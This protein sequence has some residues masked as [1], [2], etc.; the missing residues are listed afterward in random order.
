MSGHSRKAMTLASCLTVAIASLWMGGVAE[1]SSSTWDG[2]WSG[3]LNNQEPVS[4][5]IADGKVVAY[6]IRGG[7]PFPIGYNKVTVSTVSFGDPT[8]FTV[9]I[10]RTGG[11]SALGTAHGAMG[12]ASA[13]LTRQ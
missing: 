11:R 1:A 9:S 5:T 3:M 6:A 2:T 4:V 12:D 8:N 7:Q 10:R 13:S